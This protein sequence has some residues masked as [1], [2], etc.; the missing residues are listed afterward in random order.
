MSISQ[1]CPDGGHA[2]GH[3]QADANAWIATG[4]GPVFL[5]DHADDRAMRL[6]IA[7]APR[8]ER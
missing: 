6:T 1:P 8:L 7:V 5:P 4:P 3:G 2:S